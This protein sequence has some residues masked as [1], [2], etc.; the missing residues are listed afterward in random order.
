MRLFGRKDKK[1]FM[2]FSESAHIVVRGGEILQNVV[3]DYSDLDIKM[4][5]LTALE[6][7]G[8][9]IIEELV[10]HLN[11]SFILP[12]DP[13][14]TFQ[15]IQ[16]LSVVLDYITGVIDRMILYKA[17]PPN[18]RV[19]E[20]VKVLREGLYLQE[21]AFNLLNKLQQNKKEV[22]FCCSE[23]NRL[24]RKQDDL[25]RTGLAILF[26]NEANPIKIIKWREVYENI[27]MAQDQVQE[28]AELISSI[29][30]KYS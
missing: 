10:K 22:L 12:F 24:E 25:Y 2:L 3:D 18:D 7:E 5:R 9:R 14:D 19:I 11:T 20:M 8:D 27:E 16:R 15:L 21:K 17:G 6:H 28:V 30:V 4:N 29:V 1:L 13:E 23:I 26:E